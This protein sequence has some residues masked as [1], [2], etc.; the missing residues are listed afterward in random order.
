VSGEHRPKV[1]RQRIRATVEESLRPLTLPN[2]ITL[3]RMAM[4]PFFVLAVNGHE[5][6]LAGL[7][8]VLAGITD[9]VDGFLA[10]Y[11][12]MRS[13]VGAYLDPMADKL[14]LATAYIALTIP[15]G[16]AVVIPMWLTILALFRDILIVIVALLLYL[17]A[18]IRRFPPSKWGKATTFLHVATVTIVIVANIWPIPG[19][20]PRTL[21]YLSF[22]AVLVSGF[23]YIY[24]AAR[25][26]EALSEEL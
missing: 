8:F 15:Q 12:R 14:L 9:A 21:F 13:V 25:E 17:G 7:I 20:L 11:L 24:R 16:Q 26:V 10:R 6:A 2:F 23:H 4:I 19:W 1:D 5:F 18:G 22:V 3:L